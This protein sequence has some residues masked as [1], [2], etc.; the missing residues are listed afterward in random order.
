MTE[1]SSTASPQRTADCFLVSV[2]H[3][4]APCDIADEQ[5]DQDAEQKERRTQISRAEVKVGVNKINSDASPEDAPA[6]TVAPAGINES[7]KAERKH[8]GQRPKTA[9]RIGPEKRDQPSHDITNDLISWPD[10]V[11]ARKLAGVA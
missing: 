1:L 2:D 3:R 5:D 6:A 7:S 9:V 10:R 4:S 11:V 8:P